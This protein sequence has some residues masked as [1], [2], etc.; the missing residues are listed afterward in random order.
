[1]FTAFLLIFG[2]YHFRIFSAIFPFPYRSG[3]ATVLLK[4]AISGPMK[5]A[6]TTVP[7]PTVAPKENPTIVQNRSEEILQN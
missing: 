1:M 7:I 4:K 2:L 6:V 5:N 3:S